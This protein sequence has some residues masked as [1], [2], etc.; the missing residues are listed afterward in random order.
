MGDKKEEMLLILSSV[1]KW[2]ERYEV[3]HVSI[4]GFGESEKRYSNASAFHGCVDNEYWD[5]YVCNPKVAA[6]KSMTLEEIEK[7]LGYKIEVVS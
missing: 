1:A 7:E 4:E 6:P 3:K 5:A 2:C